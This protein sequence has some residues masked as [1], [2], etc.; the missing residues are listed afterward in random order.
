[1]QTAKTDQ[2]GRDAQADL[3]LHWVHSHIAGFVMLRLICFLYLTDVKVD[4]YG[5][6]QKSFH[7]LVVDIGD[8]IC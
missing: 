3:S 8:K 7:V 5:G 1:M 6:Y 4:M 2:T